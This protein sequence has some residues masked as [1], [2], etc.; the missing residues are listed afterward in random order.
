[1]GEQGWLDDSI[2]LV[3][4]G[5]SYGSCLAYECAKYLEH[6]MKSCTVSHLLL[7]ASPTQEDLK[8]VTLFEANKESFSNSLLKNLGSIPPVF[9]RFIEDNS[10]TVVNAIL[11][12][13]LQGMCRSELFF[14]LW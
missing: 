10:D 6:E 2:P 7:I 3:F 13:G 5:Y 1:M 9:N 12:L 8:G 11:Q 4:L 14:G